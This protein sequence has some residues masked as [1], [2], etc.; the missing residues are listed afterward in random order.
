MSSIEAH[1]PRALGPLRTGA[2]HC[3]A[4]DEYGP[5][6]GAEPSTT[7]PVHPHRSARADQRVS[8]TVA[9]QARNSSTV[10]SHPTHASVM[11]TPRSS[12]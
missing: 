4:A 6:G 9:A 7:A 8:A 3:W 5:T 1:G 10:S 11:D 2:G 12:G